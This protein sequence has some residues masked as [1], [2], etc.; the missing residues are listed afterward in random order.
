M[1]KAEA[2]VWDLDLFGVGVLGSFGECNQVVRNA[3]FQNL[4]TKKIGASLHLACRHLCIL[5]AIIFASLG[6]CCFTTGVG[7]I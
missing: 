5:V 7:D 2:P 1:G 6:D 3:L 4:K